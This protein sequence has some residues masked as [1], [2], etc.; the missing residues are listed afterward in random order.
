MNIE[1]DDTQVYYVRVALEE[2][3]KII[4]L[5]KHQDG[6]SVFPFQEEKIKK[7]LEDLK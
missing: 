4:E 6:D 2:K 7:I 5:W 3:L 1:L